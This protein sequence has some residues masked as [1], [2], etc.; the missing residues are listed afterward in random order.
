MR[1][2]MRF[3]DE[4]TLNRQMEGHFGI[5][6]DCLC[7]CLGVLPG[8]F[9][10]RDLWHFEGV[11]LGGVVAAAAARFVEVAIHRA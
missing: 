9:W 2:R 7:G 8:V 3:E 11:L 5:M 1:R 6:C 4:Q 10:R